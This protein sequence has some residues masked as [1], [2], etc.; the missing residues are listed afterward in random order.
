MDSLFNAQCSMYE[1][2]TTRLFHE[3]LTEGDKCVIAGAHKGYFATL[4]ASLVGPKGMVY[5]FEPEPQNFKDLK[6]N[7]ADYDNVRRFQFALGDKETK[8]R[9]FFNSD[10]DGGHALYDVRVYTCNVKSKEN[11]ISFEVDVKK[12][13]DV[14]EDEDLSRLRLVL[15]DVEG[16]EHSV[17]KGAINT[18]VD[19]LVPYIITEMNNSGLAQCNTSQMSLRSYMRVYGYEAYLM[20]DDRLELMPEKDVAKVKI[21][22]LECVFNVLFKHLAAR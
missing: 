8:A 18:I 21:G 13:D 22:D 3:Y 2:E 14:L 5:A 16:A 11:P 7:T 1:P 9:F 17:L 20:H 12:L 6:E 10:N 19:N 15:F 4:A